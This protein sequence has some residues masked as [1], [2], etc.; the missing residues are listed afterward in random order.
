M[1][2]KSV[3]SVMPKEKIT[4]TKLQIELLDKIES[5]KNRMCIVTYCDEDTS[6]LEKEETL[7]ELRQNLKLSTS[8]LIETMIEERR[9]A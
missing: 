8:L 7:E 2:M 9:A 4:M 1:K 5:I 3:Q 6:R